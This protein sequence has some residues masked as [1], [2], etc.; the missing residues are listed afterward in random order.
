MN[1]SCLRSGRWSLEWPNVTA[2]V[3]LPRRGRPSASVYWPCTLTEV[4][5][6]CISEVSTPNSATTPT[7]SSVSRLARSRVEQRHQRPADPV[8]VEPPGVPG[9]Q[10]EQARRVRGGPLAQRVQR[11]PPDQQV[12]HHQ[13]DRRGRRQLEPT[14]R[15][16]QP[17]G[18]QSIQPD[19]V[20][21]MV[22][23][24][25]RSQPV[26]GQPERAT[27]RRVHAHLPLTL[28]L[29]VCYTDR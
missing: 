10:P 20:Q 2:A 28:S 11:C 16:R 12:H 19:P 3:G 17:P 21:E 7:I 22:D 24:R 8:V 1:T 26:A 15:R 9:R 14:I 6:L 13:P 18:Q 4:E 23:Q 25:Q 27:L 29:T 5:S